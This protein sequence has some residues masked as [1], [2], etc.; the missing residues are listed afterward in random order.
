MQEI[1]NLLNDP[2]V[3]TGV[4]VAAILLIVLFFIAFPSRSTR[5]ETAGPQQQQPVRAELTEAGLVH[6]LLSDRKYRS[7]P[8]ETLAH[9]IGGFDGDE[10]RQLLVRAGAIRFTA[11]DGSEHWGLLDRNRRQIGDMRGP[12]AEPGAER[13]G[14]G[15][16]RLVP[17]LKSLAKRQRATNEPGGD[18]PS[19]DAPSS[20]TPGPSITERLGL[21]RARGDAKNTTTEANKDG[22]AQ[23]KPVPANPITGTPDSKEP[24]IDLTPAPQPTKRADTP[25][26]DSS[27]DDTAQTGTPAANSDIAE[28]KRQA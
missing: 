19:S 12:A 5:S 18:A 8:F 3:L 1:I 14:R 10:L 27:G 25:E 22:A 2:R 7:L 15:L 20:K 26:P 17:A 6:E 23:A 28:T 9:H 21:G 11:S 16:G 4:A 13:P 24:Q